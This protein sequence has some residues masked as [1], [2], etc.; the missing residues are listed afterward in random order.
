MGIS[1]YIHKKI[2]KNYIGILISICL[3]SFAHGFYDGVIFHQELS[4]LF[5]FVFIGLIILQFW[6]LKTALGFSEFRGKLTDKTFAH[7][8]K[9]TFLNCSKCDLSIRSKELLFWK[10]KAGICDNCGSYVF[11]AENMYNL[12]K[13][14]RP[15]KNYQKYIKNLPSYERITPLDVNKKI[16]FNIKRKFLSANIND[17]AIWLDE[18]NNYDREE[19]FE[20]PII[21]ILLKYLGLRYINNK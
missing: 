17:L 20:I 6:L 8:D 4:F 13:Y 14:F 9:T 18:N 15:I 19:I 21:G 3:A 10:I 5:R 7:G 2:R 12:F 11:N 16:L 1:F